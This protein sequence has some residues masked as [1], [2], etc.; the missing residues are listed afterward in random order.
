MT[1]TITADR[2][3][4]PGGVIEPARIVVDDTV[5][6]SVESGGPGDLHGAWVLPGGVD[7]HCHGGGGASLMA[8]DLDEVRT[9][10]AFHRARG[11]TTSLISLV[12]AP[13]EVLCGQLERI[14]GWLDDPA[15]GLADDVAGIHLEGPFLSTVRCGALDP[16][17]AI[18]ATPEAVDRLLAAAGG[19]LRVITVAPERPGVSRVIGR[20]A[21]AGVVV[22]VGHTDASAEIVHEAI[23]LGARHVTHLGNAMAPFHQR[24]PGPFGAAL[25]DDAVNC[26]VIAD[27]HHIHPDT[28]RLAFAVKGAERVSLCTDAV[29]AAGIADG[30][31]DLGGRPLTVTDGVVRLD[32]TGALAGSTLTLGEAV[33]NAAEWGIA[34]GR[35]AA[36]VA[37]NPARLIGLEDRGTIETGR[38]ADLCVFDAD[39]RLIGIVAGGKPVDPDGV[40]AVDR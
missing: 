37:Q 38:R 17:T 40:G 27:G 31:S 33:M 8:P 29:A 16:R 26:E 25:V 4:T 3:V 19:W 22:A 7:L 39:F 30:A 34:P 23:R 12:S 21:A 9:A 28:V 35:I 15:T 2:A 10:L 13:V 11:T 14:A 24:V 5:I 36:A 18:D 1:L 32:A 20:L 6:R